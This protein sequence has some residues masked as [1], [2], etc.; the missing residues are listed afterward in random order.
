MTET[1]GASAPATQAPAAA[2]SAPASPV[3]TAPPLASTAP[4]SVTT[5]APPVETPQAA[6]P[7][8][9][10]E[11]TSSAAPAATPPVSLLGQE[12]P[13]VEPA[14]TEQTPDPKAA[15][16]STE[17]KE[18]KKEE[19]S[20][21][22]EPA[23]LPTFE[24]FK[25]PEGF[26]PDDARL[27]EFTK[28]LAEFETATKADH[29]KMQEFGQKLVD[30]HIAE[31]QRLND[32]Y[33]TAWE[34]QKSDWKESFEK[35]PEIGLNR[36]ETTVKAAQEF[37]RTHGGSEAQ[38]AEFR[39]LM[40]TTGVGN[41]PALIRILAKANAVLGEGQPLPGARPPAQPQGKAQ[42]RYSGTAAT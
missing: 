35:D 15:D 38:Q 12:P 18:T 10:P 41:H 8:S 13:K 26:S 28:E 27:G 33:R 11:A 3:A 32:F 42:R 5:S 16:K 7:P 1:P 31:V 34:K 20:Q 30:K 19:G 21:S 14:K 29:A 36:T 40:N 22:V 2:P 17:V 4:A 25:L 9:P 37:I 23:P 6:S 39:S 24:A